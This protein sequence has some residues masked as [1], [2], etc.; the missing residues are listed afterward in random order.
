[1]G[2]L[3]C[4]TVCGNQSSHVLRVVFCNSRYVERIISHRLRLTL[5]CGL[6]TWLHDRPKISQ[7]HMTDLPLPTGPM[8]PLI[9]DSVL[10]NA[11]PVGDAMYVR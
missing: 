1:M 8:T 5:S 2:A 11:T 9:L 6:A 10:W 3:M 7:Q 4:I